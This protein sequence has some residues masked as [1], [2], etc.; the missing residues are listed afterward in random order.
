MLYEQNSF[1]IIF[2][3]KF[4]AKKNRVYHSISNIYWHSLCL[5]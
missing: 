2:F 5:I 1:D 4:K 3:L